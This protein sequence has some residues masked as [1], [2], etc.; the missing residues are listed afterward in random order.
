M[1][2]ILE[3]KLDFLGLE[4]YS[5]DTEGNVWSSL[6]GKEK[7]LK[8]L[9]PMKNSVGY[10]QVYLPQKCGKYKWFR[11]HRLVAIA[12][13]PNIENKSS[14]DHINGDKTDNRVSN[15]CWVTHKENHNNPIAIERHRKAISKAR[16]LIKNHKGGRKRKAILQFD[17]KGNLIKEWDSCYNVHDELGYTTSYI[18]H[19]AKKNKVAF[20]SI[21]KYK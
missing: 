11:I 5:V 17:L 6:Y 13:I 20:K 14:V 7:E 10:Y 2:A 12:F 4:G 1:K 21:W 3:R 9:K 16:S 8:K 15:L 18:S 19:C